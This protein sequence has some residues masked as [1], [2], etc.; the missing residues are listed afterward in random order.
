MNRFFLLW[1]STFLLPLSAQ[2]L[3]GQK[4]S[5]STTHGS[6]PSNRVVY[7][8]HDLNED[9]P[10]PKTVLEPI[11]PP[12]HPQ[13]NQFGLSATS[14]YWNHYAALAG[15][16]DNCDNFNGRKIISSYF[17]NTRYME[18]ELIYYH[19]DPYVPPF[20][21]IDLSLNPPR[22]TA[23]TSFFHTPGLARETIGNSKSFSQIADSI[24][25]TPR[26]P[27]VNGIAVD[28]LPIAVGHGA[29]TNIFRDIEQKDRTANEIRF[30]AVIGIGSTYKGSPI[31]KAIESGKLKSFNEKAKDALDGGDKKF[32]DAVS[33][34]VLGF[35]LGAILSDLTKYSSNVIKGIVGG[36]SFVNFG[37]DFID[38]GGQSYFGKYFSDF[39]DFMD[40][41]Y[42]PKAS[43]NVS[44]KMPS[45][46]K[47]GSSFLTQQ[48]TYVATSQTPAISLNG[49]VKKDKAYFEAAVHS[50]PAS[51]TQYQC[52]DVF[53]AP[54]ADVFSSRAVGS[55]AT[56]KTSAP[57][58]FAAIAAT[59]GVLKIIKGIG[60]PPDPWSFISGLY[61]IFTSIP[62]VDEISKKYEKGEKWLKEEANTG[63][64]ETIEAYRDETFTGR[65]RVDPCRQSNR[66]DPDCDAEPYYEDY[67]ATRRIYE[68][69]DALVPVASQRNPREPNWTPGQPSELNLQVD[70][71]NHFSQA[72]HPRVRQALNSVYNGDIHRNNRQLQDAFR[73]FEK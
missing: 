22:L 70:G 36:A 2:E 25:I 33:D 1:I 23:K 29:A 54:G 21:R 9:I 73:V 34:K 5:S 27:N 50:L 15:Y 72:N 42:S 10:S 58:T 3:F 51:H 56:S 37:L 30:G 69:S 41:S 17:R 57:I 18:P 59:I 64:L 28:A 60:P 43:N 45:D 40:G 26:V 38:L 12:G 32:L 66:F 47:P 14:R 24:R 63:W 20:L 13:A 44:R 6:L 35:I 19:T 4:N 53:N 67:T 65:R 11:R 8:M 61:G 39:H 68:D 49:T 7:W 52:V 71:A 16:P 62:K 55:Y 46:V 48:N 31:V